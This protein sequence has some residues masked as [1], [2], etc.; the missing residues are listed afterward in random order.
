MASYYIK[1]LSAVPARGGK[2]ISMKK[3]R[4][5]LS[6]AIAMILSVVCAVPAYADQ[7]RVESAYTGDESNIG[8]YIALICIT[9]AV[10]A[11]VLIYVKV[12]KKKKAAQES[13]VELEGVT[14]EPADKLES[15]PDEKPESE[16]KS[17]E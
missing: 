8:H 14:D 15:L 5:I 13:K 11:G 9:A 3:L 12:S 4:S 6:A 7:F 10:L 17:E 1:R 16:N 2:E